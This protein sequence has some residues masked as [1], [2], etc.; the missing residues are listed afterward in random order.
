MP[1]LLF[2]DEQKATLAKEA[3]ITGVPDTNTFDKEYDPATG[4]Q[5]LYMK[6]GTS[7]KFFGNKPTTVKL[8]GQDALNAQVDYVKQ[9]YGGKTMQDIYGAMISTAPSTKVDIRNK[10]MA[11]PGG[12]GSQLEGITQQIQN[13]QKLKA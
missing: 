7:G 13:L 4:E 5:K 10:I 11:G 1:K 12:I 3:G 2:T 8:Q 6:L 9:Q